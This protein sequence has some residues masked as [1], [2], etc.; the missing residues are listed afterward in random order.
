MSPIEGALTVAT[1]VLAGS[2]IGA[3]LARRAPGPRD[4]LDRRDPRDRAERR[5]AQDD[6]DLLRLAR[7]DRGRR[8][9][10]HP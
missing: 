5:R 1:A 2:P 8:R 7:H 9:D 4:R 3:Y 6:R 10:P